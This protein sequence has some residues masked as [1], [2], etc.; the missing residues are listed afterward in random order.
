MYKFLLSDVGGEKRFA[1]AVAKRL[2]LLGALTQ[3][4]R[5]A[6]GQSNALG[7]G[8]FDMDNKFGKRA[9]KQMLDSIWSCKDSALIDAPDSCVCEALKLIDSHLTTV[10]EEVGG[11]G[12]WRMGLDPYDDDTDSVRTFYGMMS[13]LLLGPCDRLAD[14]R[15]AA[16]REG[17]S[18]SKYIES[19]ENGTES[20]EVIKPKIDAEVQEAKVAGLNFHVLSNIWLYDVGVTR[21]SS[22]NGRSGTSM[23]VPKFLNRCLGMNLA[24]QKLLTDHFLD[25][26]QTEV[27]SAR[28]AGTYDHG[29][30]TVTGNSVTIQKPRSFCFR[31]IEAMYERVLVYKVSVDRGLSSETALQLYQEALSLNDENGSEARGRQPIKTGFYMD[32]RQTYKVPKMFLIINQGSANKSCIIV[33][34]ND[35]KTTWANGTVRDRLYAGYRFKPCNDV[36]DALKKWTREFNMADVPYSQWYQQSCRGRHVER[37]YVCE[38]FH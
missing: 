10:L 6:T 16:I 38:T 12:D 33:R 22:E 7:L 35:G 31:G 37:E 23:S 2:A 29:I 26:L 9:M 32:D 3:G 8:G 30:K 25:H 21:G 19:L 14:H 28:R 4:D 13:T 5:R 20:K 17:K 1:A 11:D 15:V 36:D 24:R 18:V 34:P 27:L